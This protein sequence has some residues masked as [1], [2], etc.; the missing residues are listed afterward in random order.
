MD[1]LVLVF[2][3]AA[4]ILGGVGAWLR[5]ARIVGVGLAV[6]AFAA[7]LPRF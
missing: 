6:L 3:I 5:D 1:L 4:L 7:L 2:I